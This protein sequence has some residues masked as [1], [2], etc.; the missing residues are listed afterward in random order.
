[1]LVHS[2]AK[3]MN[4]G[5][6]HGIESPKDHIETAKCVMQKNSQVISLAKLQPM[7]CL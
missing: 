5:N 4:A 1:M 7:I 6:F 2:T 3:C